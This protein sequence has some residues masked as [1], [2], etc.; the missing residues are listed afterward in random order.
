MRVHGYGSGGGGAGDEC[1]FW[2]FWV[3]VSWD[4]SWGCVG[5]GVKVEL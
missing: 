4:F 5:G 2:G 1:Y 3:G